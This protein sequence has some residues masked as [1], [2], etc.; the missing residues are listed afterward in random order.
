ME[1]CGFPN[2]VYFYR[3]QDGS[4]I[5]TNKFVLL[6]NG[7]LHIEGPRFGLQVGSCS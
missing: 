5:E 2:G 1:R 6:D 7:G 3:L 4:F